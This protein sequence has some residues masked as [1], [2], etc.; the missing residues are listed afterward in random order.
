MNQND[1]MNGNGMQ[2]LSATYPELYYRLQPYISMVLDELDLNF[3]DDMPNREM[4]E[5]I[6]ER[7]FTD[8][9][10][11]YPDLEQYLG[12][13]STFSNDNSKDA[14][15]AI[16]RSPRYRRRFRR[17]GPLRDIIDILF[18]SDFYRRR[19]RR[20]PYYYGY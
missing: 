1:I 18:F 6:T 17:R 4:L 3:G 19:R 2:D 13:Q 15:D 8:I 14:A 11:M 9:L 10:E 20:P 7:I 16:T 12:D 5:Q